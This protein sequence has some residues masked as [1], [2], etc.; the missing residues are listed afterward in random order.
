M[1]E[2]QRSF[3]IF[4]TLISRRCIWPGAV[5]DAVEQRSGRAGF[6]ATRRWA[7]QALG[8]QEYTLADIYGVLA[9]AMH[10]GAEQAQALLMLEVQVEL[11]TVIPVADNIARVEADSL[12]ITD[13]YLP[14]VV[15]RQLLQ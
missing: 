1:S 7:E 11:D 15:I 9:R 13:M 6:A 8:D 3:D 2:L 10:L 12:L 14:E 4:D 5:F